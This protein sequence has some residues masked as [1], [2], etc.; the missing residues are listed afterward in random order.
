MSGPGREVDIKANCGI[1]RA[2]NFTSVA[3]NSS[4]RKPDRFLVL[5][6]GVLSARTYFHLALNGKVL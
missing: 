3:N 2:A 6:V 5:L 4:S 1:V